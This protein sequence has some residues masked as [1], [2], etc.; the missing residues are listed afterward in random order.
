MRRLLY[1]G[2]LRRNKGYKKTDIANAVGYAASYH[3]VPSGR[4]GSRRSIR[5][6]RLRPLR[7]DTAMRGDVSG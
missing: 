7:A 2:A 6:S 5:A 3:G 1:P 4:S